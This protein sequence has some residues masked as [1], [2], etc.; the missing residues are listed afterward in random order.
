MAAVETA[1]EDLEAGFGLP[2]LGERLMGGVDCASAASPAAST[3]PAITLSQIARC[4][5][6][7]RSRVSGRVNR[8]ETAEEPAALNRGAPAGS[9]DRPRRR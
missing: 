1:K 5:A 8:L 6:R 3:S 4:C 2:D 7:N 9:G